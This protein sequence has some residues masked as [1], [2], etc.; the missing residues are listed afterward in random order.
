MASRWVRAQDAPSR[1]PLIWVGS[2]QRDVRQ[3]PDEAR[4][5][6][7]QAL[8]YVQWGEMPKDVAPMK[9]VGAGCYEICTQTAEG[10]W[11]VLYV[12]RFAEGV[13]VIHAFQK[14]TNKTP[15]DVMRLARE[16]YQE[17]EAIRR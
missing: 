12:A 11:R 2:T 15:A 14:K 6:I 9:A 13:Y 7:G 10:W 1:K 16:R 5:Q 4:H 8:R 3:F 17:L